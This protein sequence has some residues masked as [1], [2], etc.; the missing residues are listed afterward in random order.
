[1]QPDG[2]PGWVETARDGEGGHAGMIGADRHL[3]A[4]LHQHRVAKDFLA[5]E[6]CR[7]GR[8]GEQGINAVSAARVKGVGQVFADHG[9]DLEGTLVIISGVRSGGN[10]HAHQDTQFGLGAETLRAGEPVEF[11]EVLKRLVSAEAIF[12]AIKAVQVAGSFHARYHKIGWNAETGI[13]HGHIFNDF[14]TAFGK[15]FG[16]VKDCL[17]DLFLNGLV[18]DLTGF[19]IGISDVVVV[20]GKTDAQALY[21]LLKS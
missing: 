4:V 17:A 3:V 8:G 16:R 6:G 11:V 19:G 12:D 5:L 1:M 10:V 7:G 20:G 18:A 21:V 14:G 13:G 2:Q 9:A 15:R